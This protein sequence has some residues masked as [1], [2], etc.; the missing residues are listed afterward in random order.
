M[1][2]N[3]MASGR[4][5]EL[6]LSYYDISVREDFMRASHA[7]TVDAAALLAHSGGDGVHW[8]LEEPSD[9]NV[10]AVALGAGASIP[11]HVNGTLDVL[12]VGMT[13]NGRVEVEGE[14]LPLA[15]GTVVHVPKGTRRAV[16]AGPDGVGYL[17][18]HRRRGPLQLGSRGATDASSPA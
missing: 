8:T 18:V 4:R 15:A 12:V 3:M 2:W 14:S 5:A 10:N 9:L 1:W 16:H 6:L 11:A 7:I 13:G 17:S